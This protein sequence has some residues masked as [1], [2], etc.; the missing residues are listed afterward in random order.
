MPSFHITRNRIAESTLICTL[1]S[2]YLTRH[3]FEVW[4]WRPFVL[5]LIFS[6][7]IV[8]IVSSKRSLKEIYLAKNNTKKSLFHGLIG[9][10][11]L[12]SISVVIL[13]HVLGGFYLAPEL[14]ELVWWFPLAS[15]LGHLLTTGLFEEVFFRGF[16]QMHLRNYFS[17]FWVVLVQAIIFAL[18]HPRYYIEGLYYI[19]FLVFMFGIFAGFI[20]LR[21][22]NLGGPILM[23]G[24]FNTAGAMLFFVSPIVPSG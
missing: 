1:L 8:Y 17:S 15:F 20:A 12:I 21:T 7:P 9:S 23:H 11:V 6:V 5:I 4:G 3:R 16:L 13:H 19:S 14:K 22:E 2:L 24:L 18:L 10:I